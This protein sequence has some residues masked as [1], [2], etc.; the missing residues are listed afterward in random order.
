VPVLEVNAANTSGETVDLTSITV[1]GTGTGNLATGIVS[2]QLYLANASG[3]ATGS[4]L[5]TVNNPFA[6]G[7]TVTINFPGTV[8]AG[9]S[10][11]YLVTYS[12][13]NTPT[14]G[15]YGANIANAAGLSGQG[16][17]SGKG[18]QVVG[19]PVNGAVDMVNAATMTPTAT[20]TLT[21]TPTLTA[22]AAPGNGVVVY[23]NPGKGGP[24]NIN[25]P[26]Q[27]VTS[28]VRVE[29]FTTAFRKVQDTTFPKIPAGMDVSIDMTDRWGNLLANGLYYVVVT[30]NP[31]NG[32]GA[33]PIRLIGKMLLLR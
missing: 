25:I 3:A 22:T 6:S 17:T 15:T 7:N 1:T 30:A 24:V 12:Y 8:G 16:A 10:Q 18:I 31:E 28:D 27:M 2:V 33:A 19:A 4:P 20:H 26:G 14:A 21:A 23:P 9:T 11:N 32:T 29:I 13:S 5:A